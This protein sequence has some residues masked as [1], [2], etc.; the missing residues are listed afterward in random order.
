VDARVWRD[1]Q[2]SK[3]YSIRLSVSSFNLTNHFN[4]EAFHANIADPAFGMFFGT[5]HRH[6]TADF[7][8]LF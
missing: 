4:P 5:R 7:D 8:V 3:K 2:V 6:F 1:F